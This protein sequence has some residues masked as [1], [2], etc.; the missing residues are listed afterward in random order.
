MIRSRALR[1]F[2]VA[3]FLGACL[4]ACGCSKF[5]SDWRSPALMKA[6]QD[7]DRFAGR[8]KGHWKSVAS[9]HSGSLRCIASRL[10]QQN[11]RARFN[12]SWALLLRFEYTAVMKVDQRADATYFAG[13]ADLG[14]MAGG[15]YRYDGHTDGRVF[16]CKYESSNDHGYFKLTRP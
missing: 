3:L 14:K 16:Y 12:A 11:Y 15:V 5:E 13:E 2:V 10:D 8:W 9:G 6:P 7:A 4:L 1:P